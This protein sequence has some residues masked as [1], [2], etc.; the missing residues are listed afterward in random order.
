MLL[1]EIGRVTAVVFFQVFSYFDHWLWDLIP[2]TQ[3]LSTYDASYN[4]NALSFLHVKTEPKVKMAILVWQ[5]PINVHKLGHL[6]INNV[7]A[8]VEHIL[9]QNSLRLNR[10]T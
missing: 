10:L 7:V 4:S 2:S 3:E 6:P 5:T 9:L 8:L 1:V